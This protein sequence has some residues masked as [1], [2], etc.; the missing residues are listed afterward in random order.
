MPRMT[1]VPPFKTDEMREI[2]PL[3]E[4]MRVH[5]AYNHYPP[6]HE[7]FV[8][9]CWEAVRAAQGGDWQKVITMPNGIKKSAGDIVRELH[10]DDF[11]ELIENEDGPC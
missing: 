4:V 1:D 2:V 5:L 10:L 7:A 6:V 11:L 3:D 8:P 9:T